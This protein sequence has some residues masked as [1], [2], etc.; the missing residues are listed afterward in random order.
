MP[1]FPRKPKRIGLALSGGAVR[2][3]A[4][5]GVLQVLERE[6]IIPD[7][8]AGTSAGAIV[9]A[10]YAAGV[11]TATMSAVFRT[12]RWPRLA[13]FSL[14][15]GLSLF[16]TEPMEAFIREQIGVQTFDELQRPFAAV[17][18]DILTGERVV[19][20]EGSVARAVRASAA[21][22]GLFPP[23]EMNGRLLVDGGVVDNLPV[24][25]VREMG[26]DY[27]IAIDLIPP[28]VS[29]PHPS[30][31]FE[32]LLMAAN[33]LVRQNH[34]DPQSVDCYIQ[35]ALGGYAPW[36]FSHGPEMEALGRAAAEAVI[37]KIKRDLGLER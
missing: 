35:P 20:R 15:T 4:H 21:L 8:I 11:S 25:V 34:P 1:L 13:R 16:D 33:L 5:I 2:G 18:C 22:P 10:G 36:D 28:P 31:P 24:D 14:R 19:L 6:G 9:G 12:L 27:V 17:A 37:V 23:V 29:Q 30:N 7:V 26:A 3:A 32:M